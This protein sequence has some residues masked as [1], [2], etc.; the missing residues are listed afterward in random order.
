MRPAAPPYCLRRIAMTALLFAFTVS[1]SPLLV[2]QS[3]SYLNKIKR[4]AS[5]HHEM[6]ML[7][8]KKKD[9]SQAV[10]EACKIFDLKWPDGQ[11][12]LLLKELIGLSDEFSSHGQAAVS[13]HLLDESAKS[14]RQPE[15]QIQI[16]KEKG[17]F[18]KSLKQDDKALE[19]FSKAQ[20]I[21]NRSK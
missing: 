9:Y 6:V 3:D 13:L 20:E 11:E 10:K 4:M 19:C 21:E 8:I 15:S 2:S 5:T 16:L 7:L 14:F 12:P 1:F 17:F 18:Y